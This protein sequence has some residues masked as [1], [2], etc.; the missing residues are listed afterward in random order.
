MA[1]SGHGWSALTTRI[2]HILPRL[3]PSASLV[4]LRLLLD[5]LP[6]ER[7]TSHVCAL[8]SFDNPG[9]P[10]APLAAPVT[11]L[12]LHRR[13]DW[14]GLCRLR[15]LAAEL[16]PHLIHTWGVDISASALVTK[17][18]GLRVPI[19][20]NVRT[21]QRQRGATDFVSRRLLPPVDRIVCNGAALAA[22]YRDGAANES[23]VEVIS[24]ALSPAT[25]SLNRAAL[26]RQLGLPPESR[27]LLAVTR[28]DHR[29]R[30]KDLL[31]VTDLLHVVR[32]DL[33]TLIVGDGPQAEGLARFARQI[34]IA[35]HVHW[36]SLRDDLTQWIGAVD[37]LVVPGKRS[38][39]SWAVFQ[40]RAAGV[41]VLA[42]DCPGAREA[43][44]R[45]EHARLIKPGDRA[46]LARSIHE[47]LGDSASPPVE[48]AA[49]AANT[50]ERHQPEVVAAR[51]RSVYQQ[52]VPPPSRVAP[53]HFSSLSNSRPSACSPSA[54][55]AENRN[56][57]D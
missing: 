21:P 33:H 28:L 5:H 14:S 18:A 39:P 25:F 10:L 48:R 45:S 36:L 6:T 53:A 52:L 2:L 24:D 40:A 1:P 9:P 32:D 26:C 35:P 11:Q 29:A 46:E 3:T 37:A 41:P 47:L 55:L 44:P 30:L 31:W 7:F 12:Q 38:G 8:E 19:V 17:L 42:V 16:R 34:T 56:A 13:L 22:S 15:A 20:A 4:Q 43:I 54:S 50:G 23:Q 27:L 49:V 51:Y 57:I